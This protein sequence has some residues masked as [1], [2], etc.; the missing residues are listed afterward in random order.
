MMM[1]MIMTGGKVE[2]CSRT[3]QREEIRITMMMMMMMR[4]MIAIMG[5]GI[6]ITAGMY[7][8]ISI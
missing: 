5:Q 7:M 8:Y 4:T 2:I 3:H 6:E 1:K